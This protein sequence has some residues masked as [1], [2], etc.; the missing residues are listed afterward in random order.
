MLPTAADQWNKVVAYGDT[1]SRQR[2]PERDLQTAGFVRQI[3]VNLPM[4]L[5]LHDEHQ[6]GSAF[7]DQPVW[8]AYRALCHRDLKRACEILQSQPEPAGPIGD[9]IL[10]VSRGLIDEAAGNQLAAEKCFEHVF[11]LGVPLQATLRETGQFFKRTGSHS[12]AYECFS[13]LDQLHPG[14]MAGF[15]DNLPAEQERRYSPWAVSRLFYAERPQFYRL[16]EI[17]T[18][19][20]DE[21]GDFGAAMVL[22]ESLGSYD[23]WDIRRLPLKSL[24]DF[25]RQRALVY[26][27]LIAPRKISMSPPEIFGKDREPPVSG[28]S[29]SVFFCVLPD[30]TVCSKSNLLWAEDQVL[31][32]Y[33]G[34]ELHR[35]P[36]NAN[37]NPEVIADDGGMLSM[38][39]LGPVAT[40]STLDQ[41]FSLVGLHSWAYGHWI[42]EFMFQLW[43]CKDRPEFAM[44]PL[45]I[46]EMMPAQLRELLQFFAGKDHPIVVLGPGE[47]VRV[48][49]LWACSKIVFWPGG[50]RST[51]P[52]PDFEFS[53]T[54]AL[55]QLIT[56][57]QPNLDTL[58]SEGYPEKIYLT[59]K[60]G[61]GRSLTNRTEIEDFFQRQGFSILDFNELSML[62][63]LTHWR[64]A[65]TVVM[66]A[67][68]SIYGLLFCRPGTCIGELAGPPLEEY[69]WVA[70][71]C[72]ALGHRFLLFPF[73]NV[74]DNPGAAPMEGFRADVAS[75]PDYLEEMHRP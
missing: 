48:N 73:D 33:Q 69:L 7:A 22:A 12:K 39:D 50:E 38:L 47:R 55:A 51:R 6:P 13:L 57:L 74:I 35:I 43:A 40:Q 29:R 67:G 37:V 15:L 46:D 70:D 20:A 60:S 18:R 14:A 8:K 23:S 42:I 64:A 75:L 5:D 25:A 32:D 62:E 59:R 1:I 36:I 41:G 66:E 52:E 19:L 61:Q 21:Y 58:T 45:I 10:S 53:D 56:R 63:Q 27:E 30:I 2:R 68:S 11:R 65:R 54:R 16:R 4:N 31:L 17:K 71:M 9:S 34:S 24:Q 44:V 28:V 3:D 49:R 26:E 72:E